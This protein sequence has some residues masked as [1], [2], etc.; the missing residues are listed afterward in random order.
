MSTGVHQGP[1][2]SN[3]FTSSEFAGAPSSTSSQAASWPAPGSHRHPG[4]VLLLFSL[5]ATRHPHS[6]SLGSCSCLSAAPQSVSTIGPPD[7]NRR[8][9]RSGGDSLGV[10]RC[11]RAD[12]PRADRPRAA[13]ARS[14]ARGH[15]PRSSG[16]DR[17]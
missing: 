3:H 10:P 1:L 12:R 9:R 7:P 15:K 11:P 6:S 2:S 4:V 16:A 8:P 5:S 14:S 13:S 17:L